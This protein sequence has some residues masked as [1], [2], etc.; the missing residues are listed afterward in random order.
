M[1][2][3]TTS[4]FSVLVYFLQSLNHLQE[5][6][7]LL[8][9]KREQNPNYRPTEEERIQEILLRGSYVKLVS[10]KRIL[11]SVMLYGLLSLVQGGQDSLYPVWMINPVTNKGFGWTQ[12]EVGLLYSWL[13]PVQMLSGH[14]HVKLKYLSCLWFDVLCLIVVLFVRWSVR[15]HSFVFICLISFTSPVL[16]G[17]IG[18][19]L[20]YRYMWLSSGLLYMC[21]LFI[22]PICAWTLNKPEWVDT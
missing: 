1:C 18:R 13:G 12:T 7:A 6:M 11:L 16:N 15:F 9:E 4:F 5:G 10:D 8:K 20:G 14:I 22:T 19:L 17:I 2:A 21:C 3:K